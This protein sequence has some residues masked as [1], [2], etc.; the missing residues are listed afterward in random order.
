MLFL[1]DTICVEAQ[2]LVS[3]YQVL[4]NDTDIIL[5]FKQRVSYVDAVHSVSSAQFSM[6]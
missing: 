5:K 1:Y 3:V 4:E 6:L 2:G